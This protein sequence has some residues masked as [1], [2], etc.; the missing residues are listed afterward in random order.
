MYK[1]FQYHAKKNNSLYKRKYFAKTPPVIYHRY[2]INNIKEQRNVHSHFARCSLWKW[3]S[4]SIYVESLVTRLPF[5]KDFEKC[6]YYV[7]MSKVNR[8]SYV[9]VSFPMTQKSYIGTPQRLKKIL[10][11]HL[12]D[13]MLQQKTM[14]R[15]LRN[16]LFILFIYY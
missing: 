4:T 16:Y 5:N 12:V 9:D 15:V 11:F 2:R 3:N 7:Q 6:C 14:K 1:I 8:Y 13:N 10:S